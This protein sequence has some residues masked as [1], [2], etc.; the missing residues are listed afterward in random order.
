MN[1]SGTV[2]IVPDPTILLGDRLFEHINVISPSSENYICVYLLRRQINLNRKNVIYIDDYN[3]PLSMEEWIGTIRCSKGLVTNSYHGMVVAILSHVPFVA[4][5][6]SMNMN[7]RFYTLLSKVGLLN[8]MTADYSNYE[9]ILEN[10]INWT[11]VDAKICEFRKVG[12]NLL[13]VENESNTN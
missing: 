8:Q 4:L 2:E 1:Y 5:A 7:D 9:S 3:N 13:A 12:K 10:E 6:D 11:D